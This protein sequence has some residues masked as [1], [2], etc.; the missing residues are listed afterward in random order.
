MYKLVEFIRSIHVV[1]LF[2]IFEAVAI[3]YYANSSYYN[4]AKLLTAS[5]RVVGGTHG[6][7]ADVKHYFFLG[8]ENKA[9]QARV[10]EL[11]NELT[12]YKT[13]DKEAELAAYKDSTDTYKPPF[14]WMTASVVSN[15]INKS[16][17]FIVLNKG[18][19]DGVTRDMAVLSTGGAMVG[20]VVDC[21]AHR[22]IV[23]SILNTSFRASGKL[24]G[25]EYF[26]S[27]LWE[28][29]DRYHVTLTDVS[30]YAEPKVDM[31]VVSTGFSQ[32]FPEGI[33]IGYVES[34]AL[35]DTKMSYIISVR[36]AVDVSHLHD[37]FL[38]RNTAIDEVHALERSEEVKRLLERK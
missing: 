11:E 17:N 8:G 3:N 9:L 23:M 34:F 21:S 22:S 4:Q 2:V 7:L 16:Q 10:I 25:A 19:D 20:Y 35:N 33:R 31:E 13:A 32:Y 24:A 5:N 1:L 27:I 28:Y 30:K 37:V 6:I 29:T 14:E 15:S 38:V 36:L 26:G 12:R 18:L